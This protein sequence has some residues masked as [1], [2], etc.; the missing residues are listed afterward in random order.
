MI[1]VKLYAVS[2]AFLMALLTAGSSA[3]SYGAPQAKTKA[4]TAESQAGKQVSFATPQEAANALIEAAANFDVPALL[5][6][7]NPADKELI[8]SNDP[9]R[10]K[11]NALAFAEKARKANSITIDPKN[12]NSAT[13]VVGDLKWPFPIPLIKKNG[14]WI[15]DSNKGRDEILNRRI[16]A[17]ELDAI[18]VC[19]GFVEAEGEYASEIHDNS[20]IHQYAQRIISSPGKQ[21]GLYWQNGDGSP[22]GV[23]SNVVARAIEEGYSIDKMSA[24]HGYYF[25]VLK[26]QG[27][28]APLGKLD[29]L[30]EGAMIGGFA[31]IASPAQYR[32]T[33][34][35]T[36]IVSHEGVVYEK[37]LGPDTLNI[38]RKIE[39]Y[40]PDKTWKRTDDAWPASDSDQAAA[41]SQ[42]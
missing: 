6:M 29:Y 2:S 26:G 20:G 1:S 14:R 15:F 37:D 11:S 36:F 18:Q 7:I 4:T 41:A 12:A 38:A 5:G 22:G 27:P 17:N 33:G 10:D 35:K 28:A 3:L 13:L 42:H 34:V 32:V 19:H 8:E 21:D 30:V 39:I 31:L 40:N 23:I 16:G 9:V 25:K 24:Y